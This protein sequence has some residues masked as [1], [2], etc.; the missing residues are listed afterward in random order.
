MKWVLLSFPK[1]EKL[2]LLKVTQILNPKIPCSATR[3]EFRKIVC[4]KYEGQIGG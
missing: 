1:T 2:N 4:G 3:A